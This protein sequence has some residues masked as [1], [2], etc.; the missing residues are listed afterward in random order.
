MM[1]ESRK[2]EAVCQRG[3]ALASQMMIA[4]WSVYSYHADL[5]YYY[6]SGIML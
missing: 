5:S 2:V 1:R 3:S 6:S 4:L